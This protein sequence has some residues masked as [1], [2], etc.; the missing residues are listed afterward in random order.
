MADLKLNQG[1]TYSLKVTGI[2]NAN[3]S[4]RKRDGNMY[5]RFDI[6]LADKQGN[7]TIA[8]FLSPTEEQQDFHTGIF[9]FVKCAYVSNLGTAEIVPGEDPNGARRQY[10]ATQAPKMM[11]APAAHTNAPKDI[12]QYVANLSGKAITFAT[13]YAKDLKLAEI[14]RQPE[15]YK[16]T[17]EDIA[18]IGKW[19]AKIC[20]GMVDQINF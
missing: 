4:I 12:N 8:E 18:D 11:N 9:Q 1:E 13:G 5:H 16:I 6:T 10:E 14:A 17:E 19:A 3:K 20:S 2:K 15:G 7:T